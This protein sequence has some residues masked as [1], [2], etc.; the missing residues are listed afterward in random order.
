MTSLSNFQSVIAVSVQYECLYFVPL[1][2][3]TKLSFLSH[4]YRNIMLSFSLVIAVKLIAVE[5]YKILN[6]LFFEK[7]TN[8]P[9][10]FRSPESP[11][12]NIRI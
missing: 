8:L 12:C 1:F 5:L 3:D 7:K 2:I 6:T 11:R 4:T 10:L 9:K